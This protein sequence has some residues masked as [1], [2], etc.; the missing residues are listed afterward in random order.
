MAKGDHL[1]YAIHRR[2]SR[3]TSWDY[4]I[5][6][7]DASHI[8]PNLVQ[9]KLFP[10]LAKIFPSGDTQ[11]SAVNHILADIHNSSGMIETLTTSDISL[12]LSLMKIDTYGSREFIQEF[13]RELFSS[14]NESFFRELRDGNAEYTGHNYDVERTP[15]LAALFNDAQFAEEQSLWQPIGDYVLETILGQ[16]DS[17]YDSFLSSPCVDDQPIIRDDITYYGLLYF[18]HMVY[19][20]AHADVS[21]HMWLFYLRSFTEHL[22]EGYDTSGSKVDTNAEHPV[23]ASYLIWQTLSM[24]S[25][26]TT[27]RG[28]VSRS[29]NHQFVE[30]PDSTYENSNIPKSAAICLA[31]CYETIV[32]SNQVNENFKVYCTEIVMRVLSQCEEGFFRRA[33]VCCLLGENGYG[34]KSQFLRELN[35]LLAEIDHVIRFRIEDLTEALERKLGLLAP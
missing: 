21:Y 6:R 30:K 28:K 19:A 10:H 15:I 32:T 23:N 8:T 13:L 24:L 22:V 14:R 5:G 2:L 26:W 33:F 11:V 34:D 27:L 9:R 12:G 7:G 25:D 16:T 35:Y 18:N 17:S 4:L 20:A 31:D 3:F 29:L 1:P